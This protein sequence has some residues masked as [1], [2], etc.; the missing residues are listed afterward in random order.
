MIRDPF[1]R[2]II[3]RLEGPLDPELFERCA[4]ELLRAVYPT[5]VPIRGGADAGMD[6]AIADGEGLAFPLVCTT[7]PRV[8]RNLTRS[9]ESYV[10][11]GG[12]RRRVVVVTS[13]ALS[14]RKRNNLEKRAEKL[15]FTLVQVHD[16]AAMANLLYRSPEWCL[17][18]L[19]LTG[20]PPALSAVP[21]TERPLLTLTMLN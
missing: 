15:G 5:L 14:Q 21:L 16:Q 11:R 7:S 6:G 9:L 1:Y 12:T 10:A 20:D 2:Q 13:Q 18:L 17:A 4:T 8:I 19:N 3:D